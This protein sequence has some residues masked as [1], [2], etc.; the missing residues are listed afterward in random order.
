MHD[1]PHDAQAIP[2]AATPPAI[3]AP[4]G[5]LLLPQLVGITWLVNG[6]E[7]SGSLRVPGS[8][9]RQVTVEA[10]AL[11]GY[12]LAEPAGWTIAVGDP[13]HG[14]LIA[15]ESFDGPPG[16]IVPED[17]PIT[18]GGR[19]GPV[20]SQPGLRAPRW[21]GD[22]AEPSLARDGQGGAGAP[23]GETGACTMLFDAGS[24][25]VTVEIEVSAPPAAG[26]S[27]NLHVRMGADPGV[28]SPFEQDQRGIGRMITLAIDTHGNVALQPGS[29][30]W[31]NEGREHVAGVWRFCR[32]GQL[33]TVTTPRGETAAW[34][35]WGES[36]AWGDA[37]QLTIPFPHNDPSFRLAGIR[38]FAGAA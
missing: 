30:T 9:P 23:A 18:R 29:K 25:H 14:E 34:D 2:V 22:A 8:G 36:R 13:E 19:E 27:L 31:W 37:V 11:P 38:A 17:A 7:A 35:G 20:L 4:A 5:E 1:A 24:P 15:A 28:A 6:A 33:V 16:C 32:A 3:N 10:R 21:L 12:R 26:R